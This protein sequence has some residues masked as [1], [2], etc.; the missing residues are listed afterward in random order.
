MVV[1]MVALVAALAGTAVAG[2]GFLTKKK[3]NKTAIQRLTYVNATQNVP[4]GTGNDFTTVSA[5]CPS[6]QFPVGGGVK[7]NGDQN[8]WWDDGYL[9]ATG[10]A[11]RVANNAVQ[12]RQAVVTVACVSAK[13]STSPAG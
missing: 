13:V 12:T 2:G 10:Y 1:A 11:S 3:Y 7:L 5:N 6:G 4:V 8:T 9:T